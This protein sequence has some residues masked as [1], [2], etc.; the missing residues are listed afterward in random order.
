[1]LTLRIRHRTTYLYHAAVRLSPHRLMLR[2]RESRELRLVSQELTVSPPSSVT[3]AHDVFGNAVATAN[4][5]GGSDRLV[6]EREAVLSLSVEPWPVF[7]IAAVATGYPFAYSDADWRDLGALV[8]PQ[9]LDPE[10]RLLAWAKGFVRSEPTG[11]LSLLK[12]LSSG[13]A[14]QI[15][16]EAR[17]SEGHPGATRNSCAW[18]RLMSGPRSAVRRGSAMLASA[19]ACARVISIDPSWSTKAIPH[20]P[21]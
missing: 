7:G 11:T 21:G 19:H 13:V 2:P 15:R 9:Y 10:R 4:F 12:D 5:D 14:E 8:V 16:Y 18:N 17:E 6:I 1:M 3:G 20:T